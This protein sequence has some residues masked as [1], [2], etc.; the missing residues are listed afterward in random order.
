MTR[1]VKDAIEDALYGAKTVTSPVLLSMELRIHI[2]SARDAL[3]EFLKSHS[4]ELSAAYCICGYDSS[5]RKFKVVDSKKVDAERHGFED[6]SQV[7]LY[8]VSPANASDGAVLADLAQKIQTLKLELSTSDLAKTGHI[9]NP[10]DFDSVTTK[11]T[12][13]IKIEQEASPTDEP[14]ATKR[15]VSQQPGFFVKSTKEEVVSRQHKD[16]H[17][18]HAILKP[19]PGVVEAQD[20]DE[21]EEEGTEKRSNRKSQ[22]KSLHSMFGTEPIPSKSREEQV[23]VEVQMET[24]EKE[25]EQDPQEEEAANAEDESMEDDESKD[26]TKGAEETEESVVEMEDTLP[27]TVGDMETAPSSRVEEED[28]W[29]RTVHKPTQKLS[30]SSVDAGA[31]KAPSAKPKPSLAKIPQK[32][33]GKSKQASLTSFFKPRTK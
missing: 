32:P 14:P 4:D 30:A 27:D 17:T 20:I 13:R 22:L 33:G 24:D 9:G 12:K 6:V 10:F 16:S 7:L 11:T 23:D 5:G 29:T 15:I 21:H 19:R 26:I 2:D 1:R 31:S 8:A 28:G 25:P 18:S 3:E